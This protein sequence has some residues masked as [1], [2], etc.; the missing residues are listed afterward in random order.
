M[1]PLQIPAVY[2]MHRVLCGRVSLAMCMCDIWMYTCRPL[3]GMA[4]VHVYRFILNT[5]A[6]LSYL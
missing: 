3:F 1:T 6:T 5:L 4:I 2:A